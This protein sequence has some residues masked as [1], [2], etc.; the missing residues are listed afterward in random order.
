MEHLDAL[1]G[2]QEGHPLADHQQEDHQDLQP[3]FQMAVE[4]FAR[5]ALARQTREADKI[6]N[7]KGDTLLNKKGECHQS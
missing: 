1:K 3:N 7:F 6:G 4:A 2:G 5:S